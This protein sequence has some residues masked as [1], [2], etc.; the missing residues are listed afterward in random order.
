LGFLGKLYHRSIAGDVLRQ[1]T[2]ISLPA[3]AFPDR[4]F[5]MAPPCAE[6]NERFGPA[7]GESDQSPSQR[8]SCAIGC[9][10]AKTQ[11]LVFQSDSCTSKSWTQPRHQIGFLA[12]ENHLPTMAVKDRM[13]DPRV[14]QKCKSGRRSSACWTGLF[15]AALLLN[16]IPAYATT[17]LA[18][19]L[20]DMSFEE[21]ANIQVTSVSKKPERLGNAAASV[22]VITNED[23]RRSSAT[24]LPEALRLA[25]NLQVARVDAQNYAIS[26]RGFNNAIGNKLLVMVDGRIVYTPLFSGVFW[27]TPDVML[28]DVERI[29]VVS[30]PGG[31]LWGTNAVNGVINVITRSAKNS[32]GGLLAAGAGNLEKGTA[33]RYGGKLNNGGHYRI[34]GKYTDRDNT[35]RENGRAVRDSWH[36]AQTGFRADWEGVQEQFTLQGDTYTGDLDQTSSAAKISGI[37]LLT[38]WESKLGDGSS[39]SLLAYYDR[40]LRDIPGAYDD[41]LDVFNMEFQHSMQPVGSHSIIWGASARYGSDRVANS[42][43]L[44]FFPMDVNQ[45]WASLFAQDEVALRPDLRL[46]LGARMEHNDYTGLEFLPSTRLAW[47]LSDDRLLWTAISRTVRAPSRLDRDLYS[48]AQAPFL[49]AGNST[50]RSEVA[51]VYELGYRARPTTAVSYSITAFHTVYDHLRSL[52]LTPSGAFVVGNRM[53]GSTSGLEAWGTYQ[54]TPRW[55]LSAGFTALKER[56]RLQPGS[57]DP[58]D[59]AMAGNDPAHTWQLRSTLNISPQSELDITLRHVAALP[60]PAV[61]AYTDLDARI[62]WKL[63][64]DLELSVMGQNLFGGRHAEFGSR[65]TRSEM[66][67]SIFVNLLWHI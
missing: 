37:N 33:L 55:R 43:A 63:R 3:F 21:L 42:T 22:F 23:I 38:R 51:K 12:Y 62:G 60:N 44:A 34:Y 20:A 49:L 5:V 35:S 46:T 4:T 48:P 45:K 16:S 10:V 14:L 2:S 64:R 29:E 27:D 56:L 67:P 11:V 54:A 13:D 65:T 1:C 39:T 53:E 40:T 61:P 52:E 28:E 30:G 19:S 41:T 8:H 6:Q 66:E 18:S 17:Q 15:G 9:R 59:P 7:H 32:Q 58:A 57:T 31:T 36:K 25:P 50:F 26:A 24:T 47:Q